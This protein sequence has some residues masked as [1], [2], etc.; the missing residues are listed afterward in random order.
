LQGWTI[1]IGFARDVSNLRYLLMQAKDLSPIWFH[2]RHYAKANPVKGHDGLG[3]VW[4]VYVGRYESRNEAN[5]AIRR[6][7]AVLQNA[8]PL[9]RTFG[10][11][12]SEPYPERPPL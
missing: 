12:R 3:T 7:P 6:L 2:D 11:I 10:G 9:I 5:E 8:R 4:S 1:Q